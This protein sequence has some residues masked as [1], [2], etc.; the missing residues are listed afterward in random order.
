MLTATSSA[1]NP[2]PHLAPPS[3]TAM[4]VAA[5]TCATDA[6]S[7]AG[8]TADHQTLRALR[9]LAEVGLALLDVSITALLRL[10]AHVVEV[11][12]VAGELLDAGETVVRR[13]HPGLDHPQRERAQLEHAPAPGHGL[14]FQVGQRHDLVD[15]AH[16]ERLLR[17][18]LIAKKPDLARLLLTDDPG[19]QSG[20]VA[21]V[22]AADPWPGLTETSVVGGDGQVADH[23]QNVATPDGVAGDHRDHRL[24]Q[25]A[26][27]DLDVEDVQAADALGVDVPV[28]SANA[29][30]AARAEGLGAGAGED[31]D[32][33]SRVVAR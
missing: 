27:L 30:V 33:H 28:V 18:V 32:S 12:R 20:A 31:H 17:V 1:A 19:Q 25:A 26:D 15:Q 7:V 21:A 2:A 3:C 23:V 16:V 11:R 10:L 4:A 6:A 14:L 13:I 9:E 22:E 24:G 5:S 8:R 29:L